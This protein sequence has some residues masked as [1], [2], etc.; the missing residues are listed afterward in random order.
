VRT[1]SLC[2]GQSAD[3]E[4]ICPHCGADLVTFSTTAVALARY[5]AN[6]RVEQIRLIVPYHACAA[7]RAAEGT[8]TK[9]DVPSLPIAGCSCENGCTC[10]YEP[11]LN[12]IYP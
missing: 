4:T 2:H 3:T 11:M 9:A 1:C 10:N 6:P 12:D 7:C 5:R 8:Y